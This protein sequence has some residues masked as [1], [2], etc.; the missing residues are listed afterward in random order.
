MGMVTMKNNEM[1]TH[2]GV[3]VSVNGKY[4]NQ[5]LKL[6]TERASC[7]NFSQ[8]K[9]PSDILQFILSATVFHHKDRKQ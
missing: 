2:H 4:P 5:T 7:R 3:E 6:I 8:K 9:I 1:P